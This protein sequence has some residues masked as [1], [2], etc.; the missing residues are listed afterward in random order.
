MNTPDEAQTIARV[1]HKTATAT[2]AGERDECVP[3]FDMLARDVRAQLGHHRV[4][5][6]DVGIGLD[7]EDP[8]P[9]TL[10]RAKR[11][12]AARRLCRSETR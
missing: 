8:H 2:T 7:Q 6:V 12:G 5:R 1:K 3:G 4:A 10:Q 11:S 9:R